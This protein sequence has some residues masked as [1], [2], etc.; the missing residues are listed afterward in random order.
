MDNHH[1]RCLPSSAEVAEWAEITVEKVN[2]PKIIT[3]LNLREWLPFSEFK[4]LLSM[5]SFESSAFSNIYALGLKSCNKAPFL[6][7]YLSIKNFI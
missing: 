3:Y 6:S 7:H 4:K 2:D 5:T 1:S